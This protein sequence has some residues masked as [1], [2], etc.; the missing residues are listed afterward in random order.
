M[1]EPQTFELPPQDFRSEAPRPRIK[2]PILLFLLTCGTTYFVNG[3][4]YAVA[5]I[6]I[7][8]A[9]ELGHYLQTR[10]YG[11]PA[12]LPYFVPFPNYFGTM[13]AVIF[14]RPQWANRK[15]LFDIAITGPIAGLFPALLCSYYGLT[16]SQLATP[17]D[18]GISLG[19]PLI[20][21]AMSYMIFGPLPEGQDIILHPI[22]Y[23]G[24]VGLFITGL[25]LMP[26]GQLDGGHILY[27]LTPKYAF[28]VSAAALYG[29]IFATVLSRYWLWLPMLV[30]LLL[31]VRH[32]PA[33][34]EKVPL[35]P[36]RT[37][38]GWLMFLV[39]L[40]CFTP[41]PFRL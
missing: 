38:L 5:L 15:V 18:G 33:T 32:P 7:L 20:F 4:A 23:A 31:L 30:L 8:L 13:G 37:A 24:W 10:R 17:Q 12:S 11:V 22:A 36:L 29:A 28:A 39:L 25:N 35:D 14:S 19:E 27:A 40:G 9:H 3:L 34:D 16:I 41:V 2:L 21:K 26:I 6:T 1:D